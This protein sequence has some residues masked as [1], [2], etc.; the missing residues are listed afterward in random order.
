MAPM[1][2]G[3]DAAYVGEYDGETY[4]VQVIPTET[5]GVARGKRQV[6]L[7]IR[8]RGRTEDV[9]ELVP[10]AFTEPAV[11]TIVRRLIAEQWPR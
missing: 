5:K 1:S 7:R 9:V 11:H 8:Y 4:T 2:D 6:V 3:P 10:R